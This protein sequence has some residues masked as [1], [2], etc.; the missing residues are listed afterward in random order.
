ME[1]LQASPEPVSTFE[2]VTQTHTPRSEAGRSGS[3][4]S[5]PAVTPGCIVRSVT[6]GSDSVSPVGSAE[7][8]AKR[9]PDGTSRDTYSHTAFQAKMILE[10]CCA[11]RGRVRSLN[12]RVKGPVGA[13]TD[14]N[15]ALPMVFLL[16]NHSSGKSSFINYVLQS[17]IQE[18]GVA[19]T[20]DKF[21]VIAGGEEDA[22]K[23][24]NS[25]IGMCRP[26][27]LLCLL[28]VLDT[29]V[30]DPCALHLSGDPH[31]GF[32]GLRTFGPSLVH[33]T[34]VL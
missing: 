14:R 3:A 1:K 20:D 32:A 11:L 6:G 10:E 18:C 16:G 31:L 29:A 5:S 26:C 19:P 28:Y 15:T 17:R 25:L 8:V 22:D 23:D 30:S 2:D 7:D 21:T 24:G 12:S 9:Y 4:A 33:H 27:V 34:Q 13:D